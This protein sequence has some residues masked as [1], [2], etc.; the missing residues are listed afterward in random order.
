MMGIAEA[1]GMTLPGA[2]AIP[3]PDANHP[4]MSAKCGRRTV[5]M[6]WQELTPAA[7]L[8]RASFKNGIAVATAMG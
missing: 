3:A 7:L 5:D 4:R 2:S 6:V 8:T 1:I